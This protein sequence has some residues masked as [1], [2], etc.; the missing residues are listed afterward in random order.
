MAQQPVVPRLEAA[1]MEMG[2]GRGERE[3]AQ[4]RERTGFVVDSA[5]KAARNVPFRRRERQSGDATVART[6]GVVRHRRS[7]GC[8]LFLAGRQPVVFHSATE[9]IVRV[10]DLKEGTARSPIAVLC[11]GSQHAQGVPSGQDLEM[12]PRKTCS[13]PE[14]APP[15]R[16]FPNMEV[17][18][19]QDEGS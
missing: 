19:S 2:G 8:D 1:Q 18:K 7:S 9:M 15:Q 6:R 5:E 14:C 11:P 16:G 13:A 17:G 10:E 3:E 12:E 4:G